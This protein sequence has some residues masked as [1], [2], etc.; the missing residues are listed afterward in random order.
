M[1]WEG[2]GVS[3]GKDEPGKV[4]WTPV[5]FAPCLWQLIMHI[6]G[7]YPSRHWGHT[8][9]SLSFCPRGAHI[10]GFGNILFPIWSFMRL[11]IRESCPPLVRVGAGK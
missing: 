5:T 9:N 10:C 3:A 8:V 6:L 11:W 7:L 2:R 4:V 1:L